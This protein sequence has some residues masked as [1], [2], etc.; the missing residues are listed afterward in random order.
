MENGDALAYVKKN[1]YVD[2]KQ[3]VRSFVPSSRAKS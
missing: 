3:L 1:K 2:H